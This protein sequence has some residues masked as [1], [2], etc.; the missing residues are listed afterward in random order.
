MILD[1]LLKLADAQEST[2]SV[3]STSHVDTIAAGDAYV[4]NFFHARV[5]TAFVAAA[6]EPNGEFS[7]QTSETSDFN[8]VTTLASTGT[9]L[10]SSLIAGKTF[11]LRIPPTAKRYLRGYFTADVDGTSVIGDANKFSAGKWD[12]YIV[13]DVDM[14]NVSA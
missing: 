11:N 5:D 4:G 13:V 3:A 9:Y 12:M 2:I 1:D 14:Q 8:E 7:L 6:G 10:A